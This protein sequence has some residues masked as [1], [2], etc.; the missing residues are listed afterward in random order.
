MAF[1]ILCSAS[2]IVASDGPSPNYSPAV[3]CTRGT[4]D[5]EHVVREADNGEYK[6]HNVVGSHRY[7]ASNAVFDGIESDGDTL[8]HW[9]AAIKAVDVVDRHF[10]KGKG[11]LKAASGLDIRHTYTVKIPSKLKVAHFYVQFSRRDSGR[12][13]YL[14]LTDPNGRT[15]FHNQAN[16]GYE[17]AII[18][19]P[20]K[21]TWKVSVAINRNTSGTVNYTM[22]VDD[23]K[24]IELNTFRGTLD[25]ASNARK[26]HNYTVTIPSGLPRVQFYAQFGKV[27][28]RNMPYMKVTDPKG[29]ATFYNTRGRDFESAIINKP[30]AGKWIVRVARKKATRADIDYNIQVSDSKVLPTTG[31]WTGG[32]IYGAWDEDGYGVYKL[33]DKRR[34]SS[35]KVTWEYPYHHSGGIT[36]EI[37]NFLL[38]N[39]SIVN[40]GDGIRSRGDNIVIDGA[41]VADIHDDCVENDRKGNLLVKDS[42]FDGCYVGFSARSDHDRAFD[43]TG[44]LFE[45]RDTLLRL[46]KQPTV[47]KPE[48]YGSSPGHGN[49]FKWSQ[50][51]SRAMRLA[52]HDSIFLIT[53]NS[54][55][56]SVGLEEISKLESCSGNVIV[57]RGSGEFPNASRLPNCFRVTKNMSEWNDAVSA[58]RSRHPARPS[59]P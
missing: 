29:N 5:V 9:P 27:N 18:E 41:Y 53:A 51:S 57:W 17:S 7:D 43:G 20:K 46:E 59:H 30:R 33:S 14:K 26:H 52:V 23:D 45:I 58:W 48:K 49:L 16:A 36:L 1:G 50:D 38:E 24:S 15:T 2:A 40:H 44:N 13:Q 8:E 54:K 6:Q 47:Y 22:L 37:S 55:H 19:N 32:K 31:C 34:T 3:E 21:G 28:A 56:G 42:F 35:N 11:S 25:G 12:Q 10:A 4:H 39:I